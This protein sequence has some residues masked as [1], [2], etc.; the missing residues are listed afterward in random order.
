MIELP[1]EYTRPFIVETWRRV[2][3]PSFTK[4]AR[5]VS[6]ELSR[7]F[8]RPVTVTNR[9]L[10]G[11]TQRELKAMGK[12][13]KQY[14]Y[15]VTVIKSHPPLPPRKPEPVLLKAAIFD[16][17]TTNLD[18]MGYEGFL[19]VCC[20]LEMDKDEPITL[21][22]PHKAGGDDRG[23]LQQTI[24][25]LSAYSF[26]IGHNIAAF[27]FNWLTS[28]L[29]YHG[30]EMP[31]AWVYFDTYQVSKTLAIKSK[32]K[33]LAFL[34]DFFRIGGDENEKT[35]IYPTAWSMARSPNQDEYDAMIADCVDH[36]I[37]DVKRNRD[38]FNCIYPYAMQLSGASPWKCT[39]WRK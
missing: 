38:L 2:G 22:L 9:T 13:I 19:L 23:M 12:S 25:E 11:R 6:T 35:A 18:A 30:F 15:D 20:I 37:K 24:E 39:K 26:L 10:L 8:S 16:I 4:W 33:S 21:A 1:T 7:K 14:R 28:R 3:C 29:M 32:R 17:E 34:G 31:P 36:C 5:N 27:Y